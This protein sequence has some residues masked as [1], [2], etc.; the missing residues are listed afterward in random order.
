MLVL[1]AYNCLI[2][3]CLTARWL[4]AGAAYCLLP[5][6][7]WYCALLLAAA[8]Y[9]YWTTCLLLAWC[10]VLLAGCLQIACRC[11]LLPAC[12]SAAGTGSKARPA[13][14]RWRL[15]GRCSGWP[16][17]QRRRRYRANLR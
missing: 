17:R 13:G 9:C 14:G 7:A 10:M 4:L 12:F 5:I 6:P 15:A 1:K 3:C 2:A 11:V 8:W 16:G